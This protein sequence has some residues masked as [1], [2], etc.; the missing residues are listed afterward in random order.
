MKQTLYASFADIAN[1]E[2]AIGAL[3]D[4]GVKPQDLT[5]VANESHSERLSTYSASESLDLKDLEN[6]AKNGIT[7]TTAGDAESAAI[8]GAGVGMGLGIMSALAAMF[9]PGV[10]LVVG[11][12]TLA[13][14]LAGAAGATGAGAI[15]GGVYGYLKD[16]G[17]PENLATEYH[18]SVE[19]GGALLAIG[20]TDSPS[21]S[22]IETTLAKYSAMN[23]GEYGYPTR[24]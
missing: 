6:H 8:A 21:R 4:H 7:T 12:G 20:M 16:Q 18:T 22:E 1:A 15:A 19:G 23:I 5:L 11:G 10:G 17:V 3:L 2:R 9:L 13:L 24:V 14:A